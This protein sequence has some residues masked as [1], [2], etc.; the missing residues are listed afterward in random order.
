MANQRARA[1]RRD[2]TDAERLLW[3]LLRDRRIAGCKF[4]RQ[5]PIEPF[6][7][8]FA[9]P[10]RRLVIEADGGQHNGSGRDWRRDL[11]LRAQGWRVL[12]FWNDDIRMRTAMVVEAIAVAL[13]AGRAERV[14]Q[15]GF[16]RD[17]QMK[18]CEVRSTPHPAR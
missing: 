5:H 6:V 9:C 17:V 16:E 11:M 12:R 8:D 15:E 13:R 7:V 4:R 18:H 10:E 14:G 2:S 1:Q 3:F